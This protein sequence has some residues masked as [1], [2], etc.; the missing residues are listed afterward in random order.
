MWC[1]QNGG[2]VVY[3]TC[4]WIG[5]WEWRWIDSCGVEVELFMQSEA[6]VVHV[7]W[8]CIAMHVKCR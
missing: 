7:E 8:R 2:G 3:A 6:G 5:V 1:I 4:R